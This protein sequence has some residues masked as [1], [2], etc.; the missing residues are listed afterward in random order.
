MVGVAGNVAGVAF[1]Y[2]VPVAYRPSSIDR[3]AELSAAHPDA[4][5]ASAVSFVVGLCALAGWALSLGSRTGGTAALTGGRAIA[6]GAAFNAAG[7]VAPLV[8]VRHVLP[9]CGGEACLPTARALLGLTLTLD[10][11]FNLLLGLG[12]LLVGAAL[13]RRGS[14][15]LAILGLAAGACSLPVAGQPFSEAAARLLALAAPL[16]LAFVIATCVRMW[17]GTDVTG[18]A[19]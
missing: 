17:R 8:L 1:L 3:W 12:L 19:P 15:A 9:G 14:R 13:W 6:L 10:A 18:T 7:C 2:D 4:T 5:V 11:T 16:W